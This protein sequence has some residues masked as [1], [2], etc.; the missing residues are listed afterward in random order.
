MLCL[1]L[2]VNNTPVEFHFK[3]SSSREGDALYPSIL[4]DKNIKVSK[5]VIDDLN[6]PD[7]ARRGQEIRLPELE[8]SKVVVTLEN[9][10]NSK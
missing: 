5:V 3:I 4:E 1:N 8:N 9:P 2:W 6:Q 7:L 10:G